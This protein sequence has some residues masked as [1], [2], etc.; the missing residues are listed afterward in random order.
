MIRTGS[1]LCGQVIYSLEGEPFLV[2]LCHCL[3]C[4]KESG[5]MFST[6]A[7]WPRASF[8]YTGRIKTSHGRSFCP[9]CGGRLFNL[10]GD[11]VEVRI[12][13]LDEAPTGIVPMQ[14]GWTKRREH[15]LAPLSAVPQ[16][17]EDTNR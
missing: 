9:E 10:N 1:C 16:F 6:Y 11:H 15:W 5:S 12:G 7:K 13:S 3:D 2:G 14:E 8:E 4:R 17:S